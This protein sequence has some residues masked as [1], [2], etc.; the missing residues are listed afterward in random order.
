MAP[1]GIFFI[2]I[3]DF[4]CKSMSAKCWRDEM[5]KERRSKYSPLMIV[6]LVKPLMKTKWET[7]AFSSGF[8]IWEIREN[9]D[10]WWLLEEGGGH[11]SVSLSLSLSLPLSSDTACHYAALA[12]NFRDL[13]AFAFWVLGLKLCVTTPSSV[14]SMKLTT[15]KS[16]TFQWITPHQAAH[17]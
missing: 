6:C 11:L 1:E 14:F 8:P 17:R 16:I 12:G 13:P 2:K 7:A 4:S 9:I 15:H 10:C 5:S 3:N